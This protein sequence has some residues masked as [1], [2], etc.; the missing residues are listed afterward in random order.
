MG[1]EDDQAVGGLMGK[2]FIVCGGRDWKD[3]QAVEA[4]LDRLHARY[5]IDELATGGASGADRQ[6]EIWA[7]KHGVPCRVFPADWERYKHKAG[8]VRN[9][10]MA[11]EFDPDGVVAFPGGTGTIS[12][13]EIAKVCQITVWEPLGSAWQEAV[14]APTRLPSRG[15]ERRRASSSGSRR[16][17]RG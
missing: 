13:I 7:R 2:R 14:K 9:A 3:W 12:M 17:K 11:R 15:D 8:P 1:G 10:Q 5:V 6:A 16:T 4:A